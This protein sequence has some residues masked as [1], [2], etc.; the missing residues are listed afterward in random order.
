MALIPV[1]QNLHDEFVLYV[2]MIETEQTMDQ[3]CD[4][5]SKINIAFDK[6][7]LPDQVLRVRKLG[8]E[9]PYSRDIT[10]EEAGIQPMMSLEFFHADQ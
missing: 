10:A 3:I 7:A 9:Q 8:D 5:V 1:V 4:E 6:N 2:A